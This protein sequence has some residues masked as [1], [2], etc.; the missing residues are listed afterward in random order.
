MHASNLNCKNI[1]ISSGLVGFKGGKRST[2]FAAQK[3]AEMMGDQ[4][5]VNQITNI[6]LSFTG[7]GKKKNKKGNNKRNK[8][9]KNMHY[10][11]V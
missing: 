6:S 4:L 2:I 8:I 3:V 10:Y 11:F 5:L 7:F 9:K 1:I